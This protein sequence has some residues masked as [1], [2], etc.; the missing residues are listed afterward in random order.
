MILVSHCAS[1][2]WFASERIMRQNGGRQGHSPTEVSPG[3][4]PDDGSP[5]FALP[6]CSLP[7]A[8][9][10]HVADKRTRSTLPVS[11]GPVTPCHSVRDPQCR[12]FVWPEVLVG[13]PVIHT[14][15]RRC[16]AQ[17]VSDGPAIHP[18]E[19]HVATLQHD[20]PSVQF[21]C[22]DDQLP[23]AGPSYLLISAATGVELDLN[24]HANEC[25]E[26]LTSSGLP[27]GLEVDPTFPGQPERS[28]RRA[29]TPKPIGG[30]N[31]RGKHVSPPHRL[32]HE[33]MHSHHV[34]VAD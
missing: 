25:C 5:G 19:G 14:G 30:E 7:V 26:Q 32:V 9:I 29:H 34:N 15:R 10:D 22:I 3:R 31:A 12:I 13:R 6:G 17:C 20:S 8:K 33:D 24:T 27:L 23:Q 28:H 1:A 18:I 4:P 21:D 16:R 11:A 2:R